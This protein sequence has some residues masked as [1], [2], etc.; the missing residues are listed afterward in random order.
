MCYNTTRSSN[1]IFA[2]VM[3]LAD[4]LDS[5]SSGSD[6]VWV[7]PPPPAP[8]KATCFYKS[9][10][11]L[12]IF[13]GDIMSKQ[14]WSISGNSI[15][16]NVNGNEAHFDDIEMSGLYCDY[17]LSYGVNSDGTLSLSQKCYFPML[18]TIPNNTH[19]TYC[20]EV[21]SNERPSFLHNGVPIVEYAKRFVFDGVLTVNSYTND[22]LSITRRFFPSVDKR[23]AIELVEL[24]AESDIELTVNIDNEHIHSYGRGTKGVYV[25][26]V[27]H[28]CPR[29]IKLSKGDTLCFDIL[30]TTV[31][32]NNEL[33]LPYGREEYKLRNSRV[34]Q[35]CDDALV[36]ETDNPELDLMTRF[37]KLRAGE[38][39][40]E[41]LTGKYHSPG[42]HAYYAAIWCNDEVEYAGPHFAMTGD[43]T[44]IEASINAYKAYIP[45]MSDTY[46]RLPSSIIAEGLDIWEGA[47]DRGDAAMYLYGASLFC[48][49]LGNREVAE[50]LYPAIKWCAEY[51]ERKKLLEGVIGSDADELEGRFPTD[52]KANLSTSS[53]C[54]GGL[55]FASKLAKALGD[56]ET[57][58]IYENRANNLEIAIESYFGAELHGF[59]TYRYS[60]GFNTLRAWIC[61]PLCMG[62]NTRAED[63]LNAMLSQYL[64]TEE[65]ML[66]CER[67]S[68]NTSDTIWDRSTLYGMKCAFLSGAGDKMVKPLFD[69]CHKRLVCDRVPYAVEA[70][71]EGGK[72]HLSGESA[73]FTRVITEGIFGIMP[74]SFNSFSFV[75]NLPNGIGYMKLSKINICNASFDIETKSNKYSVYKNGDLILQGVPNS[76]RIT[77]K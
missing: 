48:L 52:K 12:I 46:H 15:V 1:L 47:G 58:S 29:L 2:G 54:Y 77:V 53:L 5:K 31:L 69:Y 32:A 76:K 3:E 57:A 72:R 20:F 8:R 22:G 49:Y 38:S 50:E 4:V 16:W 33:P 60:K 28:N 26:K 51:C 36:L 11:R 17:I 10:F 71:P 34:S 59:K 24:S 35:L 61:L 56:D 75:P 66:T 7:R 27:Y 21:A 43:K 74:E 65:G 41:T 70:Y 18:R 14:F 19:A 67:S 13:N 55:L 30:Y 62:I 23:F 63:T 73:L 44:N 39:I 9:F 37:S 45:F 42:G 25:N 6:T 68:E 64:W 40:F